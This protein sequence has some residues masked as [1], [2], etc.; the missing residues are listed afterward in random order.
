VTQGSPDELRSTSQQK[1]FC[2][3]SQVEFRLALV[4]PYFVTGP[5]NAAADAPKTRC[6]NA[7]P[8]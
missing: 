2:L 8:G 7:V 3:V 4:S 6:G 1:P 5:G